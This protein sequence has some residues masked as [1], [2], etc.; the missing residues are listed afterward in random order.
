MTVTRRVRAGLLALLLLAAGIMLSGC[1]AQ[2]DVRGSAPSDEDLV[3]IRK[4]IDTQKDLQNRFGLPITTSIADPN[5]WYYVQQDLRPQPLNPPRVIDQRVV[6]MVFNE[7]GLIQ[8]FQ[9][10][11]GILGNPDLQPDPASSSIYGPDRS[12]AQ[13]LFQ[14]IFGTVRFNQ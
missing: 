11:D 10:A 7:D 14:T 13:S 3:T 9:V 8:S 5:I 2:I 4:G 12:A 1:T 6:V